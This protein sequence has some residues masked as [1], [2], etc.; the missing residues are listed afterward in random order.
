MTIQ[1]KLIFNFIFFTAKSAFS[2]ISRLDGRAVQGKSDGKTQM[3]TVDENDSTQKWVLSDYGQ[4]I[5]NVGTN[6]PLQAW[7]GRNWI[8]N[9]E[10]KV[11]ID[12][13]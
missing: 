5:I 6:L 2:L 4:Q 13:R 10:A 3:M 7:E 1:C 8:W 9:G 12:A 11:L